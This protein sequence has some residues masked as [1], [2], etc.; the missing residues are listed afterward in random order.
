MFIE[1]CED[2]DADLSMRRFLLDRPS[3]GGDLRSVKGIF[4]AMVGSRSDWGGDIG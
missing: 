1:W 2:C 4:S 3:S